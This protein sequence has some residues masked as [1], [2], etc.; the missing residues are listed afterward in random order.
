MGT[1]VPGEGSAREYDWA[2]PLLGVRSC[3]RDVFSR[4]EVLRRRDDD[5]RCE[6]RRSRR[7]EDSFGR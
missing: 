2:P 5:S 7:V 4:S 1:G 6:C 3:D